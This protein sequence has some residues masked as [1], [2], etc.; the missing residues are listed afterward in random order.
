MV[1]PVAA[2]VRKYKD[3]SGLKPDTIYRRRLTASEYQSVVRV[4]QFL[5]SSEHQWHAIFMNCNDF[6]IEV[7]EALHM[8][9]PPSLMPPSMWV[10]LLRVLND[11]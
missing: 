11:P 8:R 6:G 4:V 1:F 5:R 2:N 7:A 3:D 9:R 10:G